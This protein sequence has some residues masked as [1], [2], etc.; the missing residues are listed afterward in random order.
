MNFQLKT[1][2]GDYLIPIQSLEKLLT[3]SGFDPSLKTAIL[4]TG[5][6]S[7]TNSTME[8]DALVAVWKAYKCRG[9]TNFIVSVGR[10]FKVSFLEP[11]TF[12]KFVVNRHWT[13]LITWTH[14]THGLLSIRMKLVESLPTVLLNY[15]KDIRRKTSILLG[16][17]LHSQFYVNRGSKTHSIQIIIATV[18][19][20]TS[21]APSA[22]TTTN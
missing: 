1:C 2:R 21:L 12:P 20:L 7:N 15:W 3:H 19:E 11:K 5:W 17:V 18:S 8:N 10:K 16:K 22:D 9:D 13:L 6:F 14:C 4:V